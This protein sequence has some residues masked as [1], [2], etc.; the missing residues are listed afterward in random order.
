MPSVFV[1]PDV[2]S[3]FAPPWQPTILYPSRGIGELWG[4]DV[5]P[6]AAGGVRGD[7]AGAGGDG[8][9]TAAGE[10]LIRLL[11]ANRAL[12]L[13]ALAEPASTTRLARRIGL[14]ASSV[15]GH[16][17]VLRDA[18]LLT[19]RRHGRHVLYERTDL[20]RRLAEQAAA[21]PPRGRS[22]SSAPSSSTRPG[23]QVSP[24]S[25]W[26]RGTPSASARSAG[27]PTDPT[28]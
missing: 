21:Y 25:M 15:S 23:G 8:S 18:G 1:W 5:K 14:A 6:E 11:G 12:L 20:G 16:L 26:I 24:W 3:G 13:A 7:G 22:P 2:V 19:A 27:T 17:A 10:A 4:R 9:D 28:E